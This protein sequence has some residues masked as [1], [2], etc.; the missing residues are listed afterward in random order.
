MICGHQEAAVGAT[1]PPPDPRVV[2][3]WNGILSDATQ[4]VL[5]A[6][7]LSNCGEPH[8]SLALCGLLASTGA[9]DGSASKIIVGRSIDITKHRASARRNG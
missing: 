8:S 6:D 5:G 7:D 3:K 9:L 2:R 4:L 1:P